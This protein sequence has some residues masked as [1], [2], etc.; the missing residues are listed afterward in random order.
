MKKF[1]R[2]I[3]HWCYYLTMI[4]FSKEF[5]LYS[6]SGKTVSV[7]EF[8]SS[9]L[10]NIM[11]IYSSKHI[12]ILHFFQFH[13]YQSL[14][15]YN[16]NLT[17]LFSKLVGQKYTLL[18]NFVDMHTWNVTKVLQKRKGPSFSL[19]RTI[20]SFIQPFIRDL[21]YRRGP[22]WFKGYG[23]LWSRQNQAFGGFQKQ[24]NKQ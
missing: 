7:S 19:S 17:H 6:R 8:Y 10:K 2:K 9:F 20:N 22:S 14:L 15:Y 13:Y 21:A 5:I 12:A 23:S 1:Q 3:Q 4:T 16:A 24:T 11:I 18:R